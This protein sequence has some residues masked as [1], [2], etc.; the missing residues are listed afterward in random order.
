[1]YNKN[2]VGSAPFLRGT[3]SGHRPEQPGC[4]NLRNGR[5][6]EYDA[7]GVHRHRAC[8]EVQHAARLY[9]VVHIEEVR[10]G[11]GLDVEIVGGPLAIGRRK[12]GLV[13]V[14][15]GLVP[16]TT[17]SRSRTFAVT[18]LNGSP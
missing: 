17:F 3:A 10:V 13:G 1:M 8:L 14:P 18:S 4:F 7:V 16:G 9:W 6:F 5:E 15:P 2:G 11:Q 12:L